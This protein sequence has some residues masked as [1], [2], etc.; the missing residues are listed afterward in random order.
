MMLKLSVTATPRLGMGFDKWQ[1]LV[2]V[3]Q[4][5]PGYR[6]PGTLTHGMRLGRLRRL[7]YRALTSRRIGREGGCSVSTH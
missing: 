1:R 2:L 3:G 6:P 7:L 4:L 5:M